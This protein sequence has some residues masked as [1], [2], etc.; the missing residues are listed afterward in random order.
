LRVKTTSA[1]CFQS[2]TAVFNRTLLRIES[3]GVGNADSFYRAIHHRR[4]G[5]VAGHLNPKMPFCTQPQ[6]F[7]RAKRRRIAKMKGARS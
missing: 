1:L 2:L 7:P 3:R 6:S 4:D 5:G